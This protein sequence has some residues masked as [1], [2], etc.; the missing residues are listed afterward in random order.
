MQ[1]TPAGSQKYSYDLRNPLRHGLD[2]SRHDYHLP[3][4]PDPA[5]GAHMKG[6]I[7]YLALLV[8]GL[9]TVAYLVHHIPRHAVTQE[10]SL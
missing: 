6:L 1:F 4:I 8:G 9:C 5:R 2:V 7:F 3:G 10:E